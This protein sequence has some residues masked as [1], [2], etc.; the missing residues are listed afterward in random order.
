MKKRFVADVDV[1][2]KRVIVRVD[3][4]VPL[5]AGKVESDKRLRASLPT[6][7]HLIQ[8]KARVVLMS[9]LGRPKGKV[10]E[11]MRLAPVAKA[12]GELLGSTVHSCPQCVGPAAEAAVAALKPG[13][14][15]LLENLRFH[16]EEEGNDPT[17]SKALGALGD[18]Y[19]NDAFGTAHRAHA[20]TEGITHHISPCVAGFLLKAELDYLHGALDNP[21]KPFTAVVGG[22][23][24]SSKIG[25]LE[26][27]LSRTDR[28]LIGGA[29]TH[30]FLKA[31]GLEIGKSFYE[32]DSMTLTERLLKEAGDRL[33][34]P[35]DYVVSD[36]FDFG[37]REIGTLSTV[38]ADKI[39]ADCFALDIGPKA[40]A[41]FSKLIKESKTIL[42][43]GP[44][45]VF[46]IEALATGTNAISEALVAAT[47][48]GAVS[49]IGG[50][51][52]AAAIE[53]AGLE[54]KVS[55]V[56]TGGGASLEFL[57]GKKL[58]GVEALDNA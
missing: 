21:R 8:A 53:Q 46:E 5:R 34:L 58:P 42:W 23:K 16:A 4:N 26:H 18:V 9:H 48:H 3:F 14:V 22:A 11:E 33:V 35:E 7:R 52:S 28:I 25:V 44:V 54:D 20:S 10:N 13:E 38:A 30:N 43:N 41:T 29:M 27:L 49:V 47:A 17:F 39:P 40:V 12:L 51:D 2:E 37:A 32:P 57:E 36:R 45:G 6:I 15:L 24:V 1:R 50:G 31:R 55:H 56:S 19:V